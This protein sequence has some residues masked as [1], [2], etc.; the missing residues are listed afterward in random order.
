MH[1]SKVAIKLTEGQ[2]KCK[3]LYPEA[4]QAFSSAQSDDNCS[5]WMAASHAFRF[6]KVCL[7]RD[8][9]SELANLN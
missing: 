3:L 4:N 2:R 1:K 8:P 5:A 7:P 9:T 6:H